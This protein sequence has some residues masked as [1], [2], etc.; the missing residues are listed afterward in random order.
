MQAVYFS[1]VPFLMRLFQNDRTSPTMYHAQLQQ[2][3]K[4]SPKCYRPVSRFTKPNSI[5]PHV[6][7]SA[8]YS[9]KKRGSSKQVFRLSFPFLA[10]R[11]AS[12]P[13]V[14]RT[15]WYESAQFPSQ[16]V[17]RSQQHRRTHGA[18]SRFHH[19]Q[20]GGG[21]PVPLGSVSPRPPRYYNA[22]RADRKKNNGQQSAPIVM[23]QAEKKSE[24]VGKT[25]K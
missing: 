8:S 16:Q 15:W 18:A 21:G 11:F 3:L 7:S 22:L 13:S 4:P 2:S 6:T 20:N 12:A 19:L 10:R 9:K 1:A 24:G 17:W 5:P 14:A 23:R 25:Q